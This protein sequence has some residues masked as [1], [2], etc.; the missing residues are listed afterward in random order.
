MQ[1]QDY[2][3]Y[4]TADDPVTSDWKVP[5]DAKMLGGLLVSTDWHRA[6]LH[7]LIRPHPY[8]FMLVYVQNIFMQ[9]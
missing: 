4:D 7:K 5:G 6:V 9:Y 1:A 2:P 8:G 3:S